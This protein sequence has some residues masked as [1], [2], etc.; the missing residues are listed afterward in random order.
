M[1]IDDALFASFEASTRDVNDACLLPPGLYTSD[2]W[3]AFEKEAIFGRSWLCVGRASQI[4]EPGDWYAFE[5]ADEPLIVV[6]DKRGDVRVLSAVCQHRGMV[7]VEG[8]GN[9]SKFTCPYHHWSYGLDGRLLGTPAMEQAI[10]FDKKDHGLPALPVELWHGFIFTTFDPDPEP[11]AP[12]L[13][14]LDE[15][16]ANFELDTSVF[17]AGKTLTDLPWNWKV[18]LENFNDPYHAS[19]LHEPLQTFAPSGMS[20]FFEWRDDANH[21]SRIQHF[22]QIDGSFNPT[23]KCLLPVF[24]RLSDDE[25]KRGMFVLIPPTLA[26]A[27]VP[28]EVAY[29]IVK[30]QSATTITIDIGYC[31]D[32]KALEEPL[33]EYLFEQAEAGVNN[34]NV[35]DVYADTMVQRGLRSRFAPRGRYS[36]QEGTLPQL[37]RWLV[38]RYRAHWPAWRDAST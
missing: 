21:V 7:V 37:N 6:R 12:S 35:Q 28:D 3:Y 9:C 38:Q 32:P 15:P 11:L 5:I 29:F 13:W 4:P 33:F 34:F 18:M 23:M 24:P 2:E 20:D 31:F 10:G 25:R 27:V 1:R 17:R 30:P 14:E 16:L 26:L 36:W 22:T 19:R 8:S